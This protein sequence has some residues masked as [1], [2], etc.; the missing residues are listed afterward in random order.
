MGVVLRLVV[1]FFKS[2]LGNAV[3]TVAG[4][5]VVDWARQRVAVQKAEKILA[6]LKGLEDILYTLESKKA[7]LVRYF[8]AQPKWDD[9]LYT[10]HALDEQIAEVKAKIQAAVRGDA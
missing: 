9:A 1:S 8:G 7:T 2:P 5:R 10:L 6:P 3:A 4:K